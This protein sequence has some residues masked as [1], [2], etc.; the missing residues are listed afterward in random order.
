[1]EPMRIP[2]GVRYRHAEPRSIRPGADPP[3][4]HAHAHGRSLIQSER[5]HMLKE[6][7]WCAL[8]S[9]VARALTSWVR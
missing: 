6:V 4:A 5:K 3:S 9:P 1:M 8:P 2:G 7:K